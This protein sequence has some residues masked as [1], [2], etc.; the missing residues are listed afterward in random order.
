M[1]VS[2]EASVTRPGL[3]QAIALLNKATSNFDVL[4]SDAASTTDATYSSTQTTGV[5]NY[6]DGSV[7]RG[8]IFWDTVN[9][10]D[11]SQDGWLNCIDL[12]QITVYE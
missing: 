1:I 3:S 10:E 7:I 2:I 5:R 6:V 9:D 4:R 11:P 8:R 12:V